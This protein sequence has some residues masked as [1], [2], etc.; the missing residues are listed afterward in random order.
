MLMRH[1]VRYAAVIALHL[2][3]RVT[4][5]PASELCRCSLYLTGSLLR[6]CLHAVHW[7]AVMPHYPH[8]A[9]VTYRCGSFRSQDLHNEID[10]LRSLLDARPTM[11][12]WT[13]AQRER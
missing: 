8:D 1:S 2:Q 11:R 12:Q 6:Y 3:L 10:N 9:V 13:E 7:K 4:L 5:S